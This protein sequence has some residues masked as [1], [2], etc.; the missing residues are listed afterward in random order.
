MGRIAGY[1]GLEAG[2]LGETVL[3][4]MARQLQHGSPDGEAVV[5]QGAGLASPARSADGRYLMAYDGELYNERELLAG[6]EQTG[7]DCTAGLTGGP[8]LVLAAWARWG[9]AALDRV[10]GPFA[11]AILDATTGELT[12]ACDPVGCVPLYVAADGSGRLAFASEIR[13]VLAA[14]VVPRRP[15]DLTVYRYLALGVHDDTERTFFDRVTR[16]LPGELAVISPAGELRR[17]TYT[18][19]FHELDLTAGAGRPDPAAGREQVVAAVQRRMASQAPVGTILTG[20]PDLDRLAD[21]FPDLI[22]SQQEPVGSLAAYADYCLMREAGRQMSVLVD[23]SA[24]GELVV[25]HLRGVAGRPGSH[26]LRRR[27]APPTPATDL[28]AAEFH[29]THGQASGRV[30]GESSHRSAEDLFRR[31]LPATLRT[32]HRNGAR[33]SV[34]RREPCLDPQLLRVLWTLDPAALRSATG[35]LLPPSGPRPPKDWPAPLAGLA[36]ELFGS[37]S[38]GNRPYVDRSAVLTAYRSGK[39]DPALGWRLLDLEL[40]LREL[41]DRD[42]TLPPASTFVDHYRAPAAPAATPTAAP[43]PPPTDDLMTVDAGA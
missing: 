19:L 24:A 15:D 14:G 32:Q 20:A 37:E 26:R 42:P 22:R 12:L 43:T 34:K 27:P 29:A 2:A 31:R 28:L 8:E 9:A 6:L 36:E 21:D 40:W 23:R 35:D 10:N 41:V 1:V 33:F 5:V 16:L 3:R 4:R 30:A 13:A 39:L 25:N 17:E 11:L 38:F 7:A 18:R